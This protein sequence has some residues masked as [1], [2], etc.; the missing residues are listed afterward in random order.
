MTGIS[1]V[2]RDTLI[3]GVLLLGAVAA[4]AAQAQT[5]G[6]SE[7]SAFIR[8]DVEG[9]SNYDLRPDSLGNAFI[10]TTTLGVGLRSFSKTDQLDFAVSGDIRAQ[11][12]PVVG[13]EVTGDN[14]LA[15]LRYDRAVDDSAFGFGIRA[16][17]ADVAFFDPLSDV[18]PSGRFDNTTGDGTRQSLRANADFALNQNGPVSLSGFGTLSDISFTDTTDPSLDGRRLGAVGADIGF[19]MS[20]ILTLTTGAYY[21]RQRYDNDEDTDRKTT[22]AD[23]GMRGNINPTTTVVAT[24]GYSEVVTD[25]NSG[26]DT[27]TG[28][29]GD[30]AFVALDK[31]GETRASFGSIV[32]ENGERYT[33]SVGKLVNWDNAILDANIGLSTNSSTDLRFV[34][35]IDYTL[36]GR[37]DRLTLGF[38]QTAGT[39]EDDENVLYS[40]ARVA[41]VHDV[42]PISS[43]ALRL[44]AGLTR[45]DDSTIDDS[46]RLNATANYNRR[47]T[48]DWSMNTGYRYRQAQYEGGPTRTSNAVYLG[49]QRDFLSSR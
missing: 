4:P 17:Q 24:I 47:L 30:V 9:N 10:W 20:P 39:N 37:R 3:V 23:V 48:R 34:G 35:N 33:V 29:V 46:Q 2:R 27:Q 25:R 31:R 8:S 19:R 44:N 5:S 36:T 38:Q 40:L 41:Y 11:D 18:D 7:K 28:I 45:Y 43:I 1:F 21:G 15:I 26:S 6:R 49:V 14:P 32:D 13:N 16:N 12:L 22:T 42:T